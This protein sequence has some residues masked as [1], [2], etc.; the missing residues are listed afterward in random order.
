MR[1]RPLCLWLNRV[2]GMLVQL[3]SLRIAVYLSLVHAESQRALMILN[4]DVDVA[5]LD[6]PADIL[7]EKVTIAL[8]IEHSAEDVRY[9]SSKRTTSMTV[10]SRISSYRKRIVRRRSTCFGLGDTCS[11]CSL[12]CGGMKLDY[13]PKNSFAT[14]TDALASLQ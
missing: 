2:S 1:V 13:V 7:R 8:D 5:A 9:F 6:R 3:G 4:I 10:R 14:S 11:Y 12:L